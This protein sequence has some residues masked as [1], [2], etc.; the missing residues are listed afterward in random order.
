NPI[1][2]SDSR[3]SLAP[4]SISANV[5]DFK[6]A[7]KT[8]PGSYLGWTPYVLDGGAGAAAGD[9]VAS[10]Y[11]DHGQGLSVSRGLGSAAQGH[12]RGS[13]KL[14]ADLDL[15][16]PDSVEKGG[17]RATLTITALSS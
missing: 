1:L 7:D 8:F 10:G 4:W 2:V 9:P 11:D 14:G 5:G 13:A 6:D 17:Y 3:R 15:K 16:I 12:P